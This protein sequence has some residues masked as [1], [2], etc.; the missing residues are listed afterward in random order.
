M[1][2]HTFLRIK[3]LRNVAII[4]QVPLTLCSLHQE[5]S[6]CLLSPRPTSSNRTPHGLAIHFSSLEHLG[7]RE[8]WLPPQNLG[9]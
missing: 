4:L 9:F 2:S 7:L 1:A 8:N 3:L 6:W 5:P